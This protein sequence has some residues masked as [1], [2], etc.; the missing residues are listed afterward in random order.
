M[1]P[2]TIGRTKSG[3]RSIRSRASS[4][5]LALAD[6]PS[7][8][9]DSTEENGQ[10]PLVEVVDFAGSSA[11]D[12]FRVPRVSSKGSGAVVLPPIFTPRALTNWVSPGLVTMEK[13]LPHC[14]H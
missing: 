7:S 13:R 3:P 8:M 1:P 14:G 2:L 4:D 6:L 12:S 11:A 9:E 10:P 5:H